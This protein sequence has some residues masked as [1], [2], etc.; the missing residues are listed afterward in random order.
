MT[1][2]QERAARDL[3]ASFEGAIER[4]FF[5]EDIP[6]KRLSAAI[7]SYAPNISPDEVPVFLWDDTTFGS[8]KDGFLLTDRR[9]YQ[10]NFLEARS[11]SDF[12][13]I[14]DFNIN[15]GALGYV[16]TPVGKSTL[17]PIKL[18]YP[19]NREATGARLIQM[20][21]ALS[22]RRVD[23]GSSISNNPAP[24]FCHGCGAAAGNNRFC[25]YCGSAL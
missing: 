4:L 22:G 10:K 17:N 18:Q 19:D 5:M 3:Q 2:T 21:F 23:D 9:L 25:E 20:I 8:G 6:N 7:K 15:S 13:E 12:S 24:L 11:S 16:L 1:S 14:T